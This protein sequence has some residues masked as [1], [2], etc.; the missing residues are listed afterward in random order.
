ML[1]LPLS[2]IQGAL[3]S[4]SEVKIAALAAWLVGHTGQR[5]YIVYRTVS[6][7][8]CCIIIFVFLWLNLSHV[9][10]YHNLEGKQRFCRCASHF[11]CFINVLLFIVDQLPWWLL[12]QYILVLMLAMTAGRK[13]RSSRK[14]SLSWTWSTFRKRSDTQE[15]VEEPIMVM[16]KAVQK[17]KHMLCMS[18]PF[19]WLD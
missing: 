10:E 13:R 12:Q 18:W 2:L 11:E 5:T 7:S 6:G 1:I 19:V 15:E 14:I 17:V 16:A 4:F 8:L 9:I 3:F